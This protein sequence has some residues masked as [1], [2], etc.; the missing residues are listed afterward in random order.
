[1]RLKS[2]NLEDLSPALAGPLPIHLDHGVAAFDGT[3]NGALDSPQFTGRVSLKNFTYEQQ[4]FQAFAAAILG[5]DQARRCCRA[6]MDV[7]A[8]DDV[9][10]D[11]SPL[12]RASPTRPPGEP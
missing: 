1:M 5:D 6:L 4:K 12:L 7:A 9:Q 8:V 11:L 10:R 3:V 2:T